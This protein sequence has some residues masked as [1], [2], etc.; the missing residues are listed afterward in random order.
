M[1]TLILELTCAGGTK[2]VGV[3]NVKLYSL[4]K[5]FLDIIK[6][7]NTH[8]YFKLDTILNIKELKE[9]D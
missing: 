3:E 8:E 1:K 7:D 6:Q 4:G 9:T 2:K 5:F